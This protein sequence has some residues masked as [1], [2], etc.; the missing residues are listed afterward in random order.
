M[1]SSVGGM[2]KGS[3]SQIEPIYTVNLISGYYKAQ[4]LASDFHVLYPGL[5][6]YMYI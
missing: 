6:L 3:T 5:Y 1:F 2:K 4:T